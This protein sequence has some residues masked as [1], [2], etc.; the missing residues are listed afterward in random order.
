MTNKKIAVPVDRQGRLEEHFGHAEW[1]ALMEI[2]DSR[3]KLAENA[4]PPPHKP[5]V[6][7]KWL[8]EQG[9]TD[10]IAGNIG[11]KAVKVLER[12]HIR[13]IVGAPKLKV[14]D[15]VQKHL[16]GSL[17]LNANSCHRH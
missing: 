1:F 17:E 12:H 6:F 13:V 15:L 2:E 8:A 11:D 16:I 5:G 7:P 3:I 14:A 9:V 4:T 10:V